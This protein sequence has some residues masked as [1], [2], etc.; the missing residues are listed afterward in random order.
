MIPKHFCLLTYNVSYYFHTMQCECESRVSRE[1][2]VSPF[3]VA[4]L[5]R[6]MCTCKFGLLDNEFFSVFFFPL[7]TKKVNCACPGKITNDERKRN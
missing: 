5:N 7:I 1:K 4:R 2:N 6:A 3:S